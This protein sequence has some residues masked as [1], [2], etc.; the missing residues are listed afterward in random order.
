[1]WQYNSL[2]LLLL[3]PVSPVSKV[4]SCFW[5]KRPMPAKHRR[6]TRPTRPPDLEQE[7]PHGSNPAGITR[8]NDPM[9]PTILVSCRIA[10]LYSSLVPNSRP[11]LGHWTIGTAQTV[12]RFEHD[13]E[14]HWHSHSRLGSS[15][16]VLQWQVMTQ[17]CA[18]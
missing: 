12:T 9:R 17:L 13:G 16:R 15:T 3:C 18:F 4:S 7:W 2:L 10:F 6:G 5:S 14:P 8:P 11:V 1:M